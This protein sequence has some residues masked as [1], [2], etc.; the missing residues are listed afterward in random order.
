MELHFDYT[1]SWVFL[2]NAFCNFNLKSSNKCQADSADLFGTMESDVN[3][4]TAWCWLF[5]EL[6][7]VLMFV[8][9]S[10]VIYVISP[11]ALSVYVTYAG[12]VS[13]CNSLGWKIIT[14]HWLNAS[15]LPLKLDKKQSQNNWD[16]PA[17]LRRPIQAVG[18]MLKLFAV[19]SVYCHQLEWAQD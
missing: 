12:N 4:V 2:L 11:P 14:I 5:Q 8:S 18:V 15:T 3:H 16:G 13:E 6:W 10:I 9:I 17:F 7:L 19:G 1:L